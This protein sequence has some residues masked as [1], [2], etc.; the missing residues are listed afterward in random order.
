VRI[1]RA[2]QDE[3]LIAADL[4]L[5][6]RAAAGELIPP[7]AHD[8][9][10]TRRWMRDDFMPR[11]ELWLAVDEDDAP[12]ALLSLE[13]DDWLEQLYVL[14]RA[15]GRGIGSALVEHA[16]RER[17]AG[18]QLWAFASNTPARRFYE[19]HG[20]VAVEHT[21]GSGNEERA[22]DVR[23]Q[24]MPH[25]RHPRDRSQPSPPTG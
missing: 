5:E 1:R 24:W 8:A 18:L 22:P 20:F 23:Y 7:P 11:A 19:S 12:L 17:P 21:D 25:A 4:Y 13:G 16:K 9:D 14:P 15:Q 3:A 6:S 2:G 10:D